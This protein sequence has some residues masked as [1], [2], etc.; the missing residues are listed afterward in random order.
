MSPR[1]AARSTGAILGTLFG[2]LIAASGCEYPGPA[3][4][5]AVAVPNPAAAPPRPLF[6]CRTRGPRLR[7]PHPE[8][9]PATTERIAATNVADTTAA[10]AAW[11]ALDPNVEHYVQAA[12]RECGPDG[13]FIVDGD[14]AI[15]DAERLRVFFDRRGQ[16]GQTS[17]TAEEAQ[18]LTYCVSAAFAGAH[19][20]VVADLEAATGAWEQVARVHFMHVA[21]QDAA[22]DARN[23]RVFFDVE[24][25]DVDG[26][27]L[28]RAFA[29]GEPRGARSL[30]IDLRTLEF[31]NQ[32][33][34]LDGVLRH[35]VG[36]LLGFRHAQPRPGAGACTDD[37]G[38]QPLASY[39]AFS[40]MRYP[41]CNGGGDE[42][43]LLTDRDRNN[44]ACQY[45]AA[46]GFVI[47]SRVCRAR[48][49]PSQSPIRVHDLAL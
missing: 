32:P 27:Y 49:P 48:L 31:T 11:R 7:A 44:A 10:S 28:A 8:P 26:L 30:H 14:V 33:L 35:A 46:T 21:D 36:H 20:K 37:A 38:F 17:W 2:V 24:P 15:G 22:C 1:R 16:M 13:K 23:D 3:A 42:P 39:D 12:A 9:I 5:P 29:P 47:D 25:V 6:T 40:V 41:Q 43:Q 34:Q 19:D 18:S 45:G 4:S